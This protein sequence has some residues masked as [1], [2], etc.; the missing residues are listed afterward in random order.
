MESIYQKFQDLIGEGN[1]T[2]DI[3]QILLRTAMVFVLTIVIIRLSDRRA[4]SLL[5]PFENVIVFLHGALLGRII[6][7]PSTPFLPAVAAAALISV[8][9]RI[10]AMLSIRSNF[11]GYLIKDEAVD[12]YRD[13]VQITRNM[14]RMNISENDLLEEARKHI[15]ADSLDKV[16]TARLERAG[17]ISFVLKEEE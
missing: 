14:K 15:N 16:K 10:V 1:D 13:G 2:L 9:H 12:L 11:F 17:N 5:S 6:L 8:L 4:Y 3:W 7:D